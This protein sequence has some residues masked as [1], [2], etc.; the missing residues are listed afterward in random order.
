[1]LDRPTHQTQSSYKR[2]F[3]RGCPAALARLEK[4]R[5]ELGDV[6]L[7]ADGAEAA[8]E[9]DGSAVELIAARCQKRYGIALGE[10]H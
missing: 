3:R 7:L 8:A 1:M 9:V 5:E 6:E 10:T 2:L 4:V